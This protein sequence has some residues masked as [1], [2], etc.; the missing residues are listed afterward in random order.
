[1]YTQIYNIPPLQIISRSNIANS[2]YK[3]NKA[4]YNLKWRE[5]QI[6]FI[7]Y[8]ME[9]NLKMYLIDIVDVDCINLVK[10]RPVGFRQK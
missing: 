4:A 6:K 7:G 2:M 3:K 9:F 10:V 1:M 8:T 5:Y